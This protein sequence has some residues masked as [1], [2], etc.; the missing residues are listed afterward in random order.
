[1]DQLLSCETHHNEPNHY[2]FPCVLSGCPAAMSSNETIS[3]FT[4][5]TAAET[6]VTENERARLRHRPRAVYSSTCIQDTEEHGNAQDREEGNNGER[7]S[8]RIS[9]EKIKQGK[10]QG[11]DR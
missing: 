11:D 4:V 9:T 3:N 7:K 6:H 8:E 1:M 10:Q 5:S 2:I